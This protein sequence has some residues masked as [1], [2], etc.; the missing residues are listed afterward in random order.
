MAVACYLCMKH[1][2]SQADELGTTKE[3]TG[4][5]LSIATAVTSGRIIMQFNEA[6]GENPSLPDKKYSETC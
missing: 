4:T 1:Y 6:S 5:V 2:L 3:D